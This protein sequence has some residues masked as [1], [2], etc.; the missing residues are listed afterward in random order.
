MIDNF[1][2]IKP[3]ASILINQLACFIIAKAG[4][5]N[6]ALSRPDFVKMPLTVIILGFIK[7]CVIIYDI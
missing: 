5:K 7:N 1:A 3:I 4:E 2:G 6:K